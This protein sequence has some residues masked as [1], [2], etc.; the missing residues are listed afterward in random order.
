MLTSKQKSF[1]RSMGQTQ[2]AIFQVGKDGM[3]VNLVNTV[4]DS[5]EAHELI[6]ISVL[7]SCPV[8][9]LEIALDLSSATHSEVVQIIG[10]T[11]LL[12]RQSEKKKIDLPR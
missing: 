12:Y 9:A 11:L 2:R 1:L 10:K 7:K 6:K 8:P 4:S 5:L 3:S